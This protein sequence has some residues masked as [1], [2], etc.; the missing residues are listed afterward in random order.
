MRFINLTR[1]T[2]IGANSYFL[3]LEGRKLVVDAGLHPKEEN[4]AALPMYRLVPDGSLDAILISHAHQDHVGS[5]PV[6]MRRQPQARVLMTHATSKLSD[7]MLH[8]S[9]NVMS[10][11]RD[12]LG[13]RGYPLFTHREADQAA[14]HWQ[15]VGLRQHWTL[16]G[17]RL[18]GPQGEPTFELYD[19]G[20]I[21]GSAGILFRAEGRKIFYTGDVNFLQQTLMRSADFPEEEIDVLIIETTRG[22]R[23]PDPSYSR[24]KEE[25]RF[26]VALEEAF[27]RGGSVLIPVFALGKTQ[28][29]L[30]MLYHF[31]RRG[32][33][34]ET[35][36]YI[37]GLSTK[38][39]V[40][41]DQLASLTTRQ[42]PGLQLLDSIGP[43]VL[44]GREIA[45]TQINRRRIY[46][47]SSGMMTEK[48]LSNQLAERLIGDP[49][50]SIF[51]VGYADP[52]SP[53][54]R[55]K[56]ARLGDQIQ[57]DGQ[58]PSGR[59]ACNVQQFDFSAHAPR[60][61]LLEYIRK[62]APRVVVL[63][64][65]DPPAVGW[66]AERIALELPATQAVIPEPGKEYEF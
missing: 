41:H 32:A 33:L 14:E 54:G 11:Q 28:E 7:I 45:T 16:S 36:I 51:F 43:F 42:H 66:F 59:L 2:E 49:R 15:S 63:V 4:E 46:A 23:A 61:M 13:T 56:A 50:Q 21:L 53:G 5:L 34:A 62:V 12:E 19:S 8:N 35:P 40:A 37:G 64:H 29:V 57:L 30:T 10:R 48:T 38:I 52:D 27:D 44:S 26:L 1:R 22:D 65:G 58:L 6:L 47:L 39:T 60:E 55:L 9:V 20:H 3:E 17:E 24:R 25:Q 31:K 18:P